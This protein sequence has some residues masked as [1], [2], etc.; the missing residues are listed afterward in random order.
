MRPCSK[1]PNQTPRPERRLRRSSEVG[2]LTAQ[3]SP[4][5][6]GHC[7]RVHTPTQ[8]FKNT[9]NLKVTCTV[10]ELA[11]SSTV[12]EVIWFHN[13]RKQG[14]FRCECGN[15]ATH[16]LSIAKPAELKCVPK[17]PCCFPFLCFKEATGIDGVLAS[18]WKGG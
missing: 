8:W 4:G 10:E 18:L 5:L 9:T 17:I 13:S 11:I 3:S 1:K 15:P 12:T 6:R 2:Q 7:T 16:L 14:L